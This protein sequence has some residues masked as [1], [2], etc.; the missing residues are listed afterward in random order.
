MTVDQ[1]QPD[2]MKV[3]V[4]SQ[5]TTAFSDIAQVA[6]RNDDIVYL[7]F[8]SDT[9]DAIIENFRTMMTKNNATKLLDILAT[10]LDYYPVKAVELK[11]VIS[12]KSKIVKSK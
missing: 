1:T 4:M 7:Q 6:I 10:T 9:P 11:P 12:K 3:R 2:Q 8:F 5:T